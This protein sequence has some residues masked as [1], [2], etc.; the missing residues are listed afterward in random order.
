MAGREISRT[1]RTTIPYLPTIWFKPLG[2]LLG[3]C[4]HEEG[5]EE[6]IREGQNKRSVDNTKTRQTREGDA[7]GM[8][9]KR[10]ESQKV[11]KKKTR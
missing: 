11:K 2:L 8:I 9:G 5:Q 7:V 4:S 10:R 1:T 3:S 6:K